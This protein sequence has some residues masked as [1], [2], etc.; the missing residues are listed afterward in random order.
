MN[1][2][3]FKKNKA[4]LAFVLSFLLGTL[5][6]LPNI[7]KGGG[8]Y[9][10]VS[11]F[12]IQE[13]PFNKMIN[14]SIKSGSILWTWFNDLGS[15][16]LATFSFYNLFS[17]FNIIGYLFPSS[18]YEYLI[19]PIFI[20]KYAVSGLTSYLFLQRYVKN[21]NYA[22]LGALLYAF[23][24]FQL[25]NTLFYHFHDVVA[26]FP[27][28]LYTLDNL[29]YEKKKCKFSMAVSL[30]LFTN[31]F[32][33][34]GE[35]IFLILYFLVKLIFKSYSV[36][37]RDILNILF[38]GIIGVA[39]T[40][41]ILI[42]TISFTLG[43][44]RIGGT[45]TLKNAFKF[46]YFS[47]YLEIIRG[48]I[49]PSELMYVR[50]F[51]TN[52]NYT[53][54]EL[55]LPFVGIVLASSYFFKKP[56][57]WENALF[58]ILCLFMFIP[59]LNSAFFAFKTNYYARWFYM[60]TLILSLMSIKCLDEKIKINNGIIFTIFCYSFLM[61]MIYIYIKLGNSN[62]VFDS[63]YMILSIIFSLLN[64]VAIYIIFNCGRIK[65]K[66]IWIFVFVFIFV[67]IWGNYMVYKYKGSTFKTND[68]YINYLKIKNNIGP[69]SIS[70]S[71][72]SDTCDYN[73]G[74][75][76]NNNNIK[77][78]NSNINGSSFEFYNSIDYNREVST[79]I[80]TSDKKLNDFLG[81]EYVISCGNDK[82]E[83]YGYTFKDKK[84]TFSIYHNDDYKKF[85]FNV[86]KY[87]STK[88]FKKLSY[89]E[90]IDALNN[91]VVLTNKQIKKYHS[92]MDNDASYELNEYK[93]MKNGFNSK[94]ISTNETLAIYTI[95]Y[96]DGW[97]ATIN[98]KKVDI[99]KVDN[100][101]IA[102]KIN[103][104]KNEIKFKYFSKGLKE[105]LMISGVS[106]IIYIIYVILY[107]KGNWCCNEKRK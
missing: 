81:V 16:F 32:F 96:D 8:I 33:F 91:S 65:H 34:I 23:S 72:S 73:I 90:K 13:I 55:F 75:T 77:S 86:N 98:G 61:L 89:E 87:V 104:G 38:E 27:L 80:K 1:C 60:P 12:N 54:V 48:F 6:I 63:S 102:V 99:E 29:I 25:T 57:R 24:G 39:L 5:I 94:I 88:E 36:S 68:T 30:C 74:Y 107:M 17:P 95:P 35:V 10:L 79:I 51:L 84:G 11:D 59:F 7:I 20:L 19:G 18:M 66:L 37:F 62:I 26:F 44:P 31:W 85:G 4:L 101:F 43:N 71:N 15:N 58:V 103:K 53:S 28:L 9:S 49:L 22:V 106:L 93:F 3:I 78:F 105:G 2:K 40:S 45:W 64:L 50:S 46:N 97:S 14:D 41:I 100:G 76:S 21:K 83:E 70:R 47:M 82:L 42:P 67:A 92:I 56:K 69:N 52:M